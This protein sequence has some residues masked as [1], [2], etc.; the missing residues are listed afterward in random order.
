MRTFGT[1][2]ACSRSDRLHLTYPMLYSISHGL[3]FPTIWVTFRVF[4]AEIALDKYLFFPKTLVI[5]IHTGR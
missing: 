4:G 3:S 1:A 5:S 2:R